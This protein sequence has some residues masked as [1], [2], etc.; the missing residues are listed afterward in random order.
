MFCTSC[1]EH[2]TYRY[3][4]LE[5]QKE[6]KN[7]SL[8]EF[9]SKL[10]FSNSNSCVKHSSSVKEITYNRNKWLLK[11][12]ENYFE[13]NNGYCDSKRFSDN[14]DCFINNDFKLRV[15]N[16]TG[17]SGNYYYT[18]YYYHVC[19]S[20]DKKIYESE[21]AYEEAKRKQAEREAERKRIEEERKKKE[22][23]ERISMLRNRKG[24]FVMDFYLMGSTPSSLDAKSCWNACSKANYNTT[25]Y[26]TIDE[27][28][29]NGWTVKQILGDISQSGVTYYNCIC[30]GKKYLM[31]KQ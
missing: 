15:K 9:L 30:Q 24:Q 5:N 4:H 16:K 11:A 25:G 21:V 8:D 29:Q 20:T 22:E 31:T 12:I 10:G 1:V 27:A 7:I 6:L 26:W 2:P 18:D 17:T 14:L 28:L 23:E 3:S 19:V 13:A